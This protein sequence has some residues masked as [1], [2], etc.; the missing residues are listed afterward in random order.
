M[1][2]ASLFNLGEALAY[3]GE[4]E[5]AIRNLDKAITILEKNDI[6]RP[7]WFQHY[8]MILKELC[9]PEKAQKILNKI[10]Q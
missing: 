3:L 9:E 2:A 7:G 10:S 1:L 6:S 4:K 8:A 5:K